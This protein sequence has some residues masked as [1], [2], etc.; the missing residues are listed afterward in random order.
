MLALAV[1]VARVR[2]NNYDLHAASACD[3]LSWL[4]SWTSAGFIIF[5]AFV[6]K[7]DDE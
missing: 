3:I 2:E 1:Y 7:Q 5:M 6:K 4:V